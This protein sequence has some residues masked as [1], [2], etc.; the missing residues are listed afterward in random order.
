[1]HARV[2]HHIF[3]FAVFGAKFAVLAAAD[4]S[5]VVLGG[6]GGGG[7]RVCRRRRG[8]DGDL[9]MSRDACEGTSVRP[10]SRA[11]CC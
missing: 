5:R 4:G 2:V 11:R 10:A 8:G 9:R 1:M 6:G 3:K 7:A